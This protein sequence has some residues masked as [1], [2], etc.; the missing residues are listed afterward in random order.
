MKTSEICF[1]TELS[2]IHF[3]NDCVHSVT[4]ESVMAITGGGQYGVLVDILL[5]CSNNVIHIVEGENIFWLGS[6]KRQTEVVDQ[7]SE[8]AKLQPVSWGRAA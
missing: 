3:D 7:I 5:G 4:I 8:M 2:F 1:D 6:K